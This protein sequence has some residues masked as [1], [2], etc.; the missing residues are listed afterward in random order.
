MLV[1]F[2]AVNPAAAVVWIIVASGCIGTTLHWYGK[3]YGWRGAESTAIAAVAE[4]DVAG[5]CKHYKTIPYDGSVRVLFSRTKEPG[6]YLDLT[7]E[8]D[9]RGKW[10]VTQ[11]NKDFV[12]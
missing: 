6:H 9:G 8:Q 4:S 3:V 5:C 7:V 1:K 11:F 12:P 10:A 2:F